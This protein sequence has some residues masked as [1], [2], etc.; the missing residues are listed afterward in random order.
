MITAAAKVR[1][2]QMAKSHAAI[3]KE[4]VSRLIFWLSERE[5][6]E[7]SRIL[8]EGRDIERREPS[9]ADRQWAKEVVEAAEAQARAA[10]GG[11]AAPG[12]GTGTS[13]KRRA[14][15]A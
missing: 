14:R 12:G 9:D 6:D 5:E 2:D 15:G 3:Q 13:G 4:L 7:Q 1:L 11:P 8:R 10:E